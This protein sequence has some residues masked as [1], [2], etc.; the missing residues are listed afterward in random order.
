MINF[1]ALHLWRMISYDLHE[2][3]WQKIKITTHYLLLI[4]SFN[5]LNLILTYFLQLYHFN[6]C[7]SINMSFFL[8]ENASILKSSHDSFS[9]WVVKKD[10]YEIT[11]AVFNQIY[12]ISY[13]LFIQI[14]KNL[15]IKISAEEK[16]KYQIIKYTD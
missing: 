13:K 10:S 1:K 2:F 11:R 15:I 12:V 14:W 9:L 16:I 6:V 4:L 5:I 3:L 7:I 8:K